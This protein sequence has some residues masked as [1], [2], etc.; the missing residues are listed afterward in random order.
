MP[1]MCLVGFCVHIIFIFPGG[2]VF[3]DIIGFPKASSPPHFYRSPKCIRPSDL[4]AAEARVLR[5]KPLSKTVIVVPPSEV[6]YSG[7]HGLPCTVK[8]ALTANICNSG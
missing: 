1:G 5:Q 8:P 7:S 4:Q 2:G 6:D 3:N